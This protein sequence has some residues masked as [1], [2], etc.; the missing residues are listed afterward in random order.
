MP[1]L[2]LKCEGSSARLSRRFS[3]PPL[4]KCTEGSPMDG[5]DKKVRSRAN[6]SSSE[7]IPMIDL[8][9]VGLSL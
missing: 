5:S 4:V 6:P 7:G 3:D 8:S 9:N 2:L 1:G